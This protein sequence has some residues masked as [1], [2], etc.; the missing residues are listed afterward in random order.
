MRIIVNRGRSICVCMTPG[1]NATDS[2]PVVRP[3]TRTYGPNSVLEMPDVDAEF[4]IAM[5]FA[6]KFEPPAEPAA[7]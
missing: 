4:Q 5:G 7:E 2:A 6:R 1:V 3:V